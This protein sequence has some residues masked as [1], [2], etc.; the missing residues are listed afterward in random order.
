MGSAGAMIGKG[1]FVARRDCLAYNRASGTLNANLAPPP[2]TTETSSTQLAQQL[3]TTTALL[4]NRPQL[5]RRSRSQQTSLW[6]VLSLT[7]N[8]KQSQKRS[9][10]MKREMC[11]HL[12]MRTTLL[13][14]QPLSVAPAVGACGATDFVAR[15]H[16]R[17]LARVIPR[18]GGAC[19]RLSV[20]PAVGA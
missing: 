13:P 16:R 17:M 20:V 15:I 6:R 10:R 11:R 8:L 1:M 9:Q 3:A 4:S 2:F 18:T 12:R 5:P 14:C 7:Q 19:P